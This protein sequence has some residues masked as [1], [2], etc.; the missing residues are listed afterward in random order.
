MCFGVHRSG[1]LVF[2]LP[3]NPVSVLVCMEEYVLPAM[4]RRSGMSSFRKRDFLGTIGTDV[5]G[6]PD[7]TCFLRSRAVPGGSGSW[8]LEVPPSSGSGDLMSTSGTNCL[9][10]L[11]PGEEAVA[12]GDVVRFHLFSSTAGEMAFE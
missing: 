10:V 4:R 8:L 1:K 2:G 12:K 9:A 3:G 6:R 7:R 5:S 11:S